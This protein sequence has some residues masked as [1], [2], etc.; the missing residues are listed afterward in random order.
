MS[1]QKK[2]LSK[3]CLTGFILSIL[4][5]ISMA[6]LSMHF[7]RTL[8]WIL[9]AFTLAMPLAG[10]ILSIVGIV[11]AK[12]KNKKGK[13][14]GVVGIVLPSIYAVIGVILI[15]LGAA[16][17]SLIKGGETDKKLPTFYS[18]SEIVAVRYYYHDSDGGYRIE[19]LDAERM[20]EFV[21][22]LNSMELGTGGM[23]DYYWGGSFGIEMELD[24]G[25]YLTY[26]G[27]RLEMLQKSRLDEDYSY[28]DK[29]KS[30]YVHVSNEDF[31]EVMNDYFP[32]IEENGDHV[33]AQTS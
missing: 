26:D 2:E 13:G 14:F 29:I 7:H 4:F 17:L 23:M 15:L 27:T 30:E 10:F 11:T 22:E 18:D 20:D 24:D 1:G 5:P 12:K 19:E 28:D 8:G 21:D 31:W 3:L 9:L 33:W 25:T 6:F 16:F 32:S